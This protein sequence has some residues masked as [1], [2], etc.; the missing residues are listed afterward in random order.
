MAELFCINIVKGKEDMFQLTTGFCESAL[1][2]PLSGDSRGETFTLRWPNPSL[3]VIDIQRFPERVVQSSTQSL[4]YLALSDTLSLIWLVIPPSTGMEELVSTFQIEIGYCVKLREYTLVAARNGRNVVVP[5]SIT[6]SNTVYPLLGNPVFNSSLFRLSAN[7]LVYRYTNTCSSS[8]AT[9]QSTPLGD[10]GARTIR[11]VVTA[12]GKGFNDCVV[13]LRVVWKNKIRQVAS[14]GIL[15]RFA[16]DCVGVDADGDAVSVSFFG[17]SVISD[18]FDV[19]DCIRCR[20]PAFVDK[21]ESGYSEKLNVFDWSSTP[22]CCA[23]AEHLIPKHPRYVFFSCSVQYLVE[24]CEVGDIVSVYGE[25][26]AFSPTTLVNTRYGHVGRSVVELRDL[27]SLQHSIEVTLWGDMGA[28]VVPV[29]GEQWCFSNFLVRI[30]GGRI[31]ASSR[32]VSSAFVMSPKGRVD[33]ASNERPEEQPPHTS[34][35][36]EVAGGTHDADIVQ[37]VFDL[38]EISESLPVLAKVKGV[39]H[40]LTYTACSACGRKVGNET[41]VCSSCPEASVEERFL[42]QLELSDGIRSA[43]AFGLESVGKELFGFDTST[44]L[45]YRKDSPNFER[46]IT[47]ELIGLPALFWLEQSLGGVTQVKRCQRV[48]M[49]RCAAV[50]LGAVE[51]IMSEGGL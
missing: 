33:V 46:L 12:E 19:G 26:A 34:K 16:V 11:Q 35:Q 15:G 44:L 6:H 23:G 27:N 41:S 49:A 20:N 1:T 4:F 17:S 24:C 7:A 45:R 32:C 25:V 28:I 22:G 30:F 10:Y 47:H 2:A 37:L 21:G 31:T 50:V 18:M 3:Q 13:Y 14:S 40:P 42:V 38:D 51:Q 9:W 29:V 36:E 8:S 43:R 48:D 39:K 5:L